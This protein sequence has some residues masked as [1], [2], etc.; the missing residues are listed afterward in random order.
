[1]QDCFRQHPDVY[2]AE[3][4]DDEEAPS[5]EQPN[6]AAEATTSSTLDETRTRAKEARDQVKADVAEKGKHSESEALVPKSAHDAEE[7]NKTV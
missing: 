4:E 3:L 2:G 5:P 1:M 6:A 7:K